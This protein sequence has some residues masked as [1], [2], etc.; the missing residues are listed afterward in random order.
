MH[1][2]AIT[3]GIFCAF[4]RKTPENRAEKPRKS[5]NF[6]NLLTNYNKLRAGGS[7]SRFATLVKIQEWSDSFYDA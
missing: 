1:Y 5:A 3:M 4:F 7:K 2:N 6:S